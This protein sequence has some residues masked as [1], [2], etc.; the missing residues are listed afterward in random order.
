MRKKKTAK[1]PPQ[2]VALLLVMTIIVVVLSTVT[3]GVTLLLN[4]LDESKSRQ[5]T[6]QALA[7]AYA[8]IEKVKGYYKNNPSFFSGCAVNDCIDFTNTSSCVACTDAK[9]MFMDSARRYRVSITAFNTTDSVALLAV[10]YR[11]LYNRTVR[12][13]VKLTTF[14]CGDPV[15][16]MIEDRDGYHYPTVQVDDKC[17]LAA[18]LLTK[19]KRDGT[20]IN[21]GG[22][23][24]CPDA[25]SSDDNQ[26]RSCYDNDEFNCTDQNR[27]ALYTWEAA[28][29]GDNDENTQGLCPDGW[30]L[31]SD[32][33]WET[34]E[35]YFTTSGDCEPARSSTL[36]NEYQCENGGD[37]LIVGG[38]SGFEAV[39]SGYREDG[40]IF[41]QYERQGKFWTSTGDK[42]TIF[43][44]LENG[45]PGVGRDEIDKQERAFSIR[46]QQDS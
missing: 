28:M 36:G 7:S 29:D 46:C 23:P 12:D 2:G 11:G 41:N 34:F 38:G 45:N 40:S 3:I 4:N 25:S 35:T 5:D 17:W 24:P 19:T 37:T 26:G 42:P 15:K 8:G 13:A 16:G 21:G 6:E 10:G 30:Y 18:N 9:A 39:Y 43:R 32:K 33:R 20:C 1:K 44:S 27:G 22:T 31:P 14:I